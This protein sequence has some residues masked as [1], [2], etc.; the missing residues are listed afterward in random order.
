MGRTSQMMLAEVQAGHV[1]AARHLG[2]QR[3]GSGP[4]G[5][6]PV[7]A[8]GT[9]RGARTSYL[10]GW[11]VIRR[12]GFTALKPLGNFSLASSSDTAGVIT[13]SS[14]SFQ[15]TGVATL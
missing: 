4:N 14:P 5:P 15:F 13:T 10:L 9:P 12:Y 11:G 2:P 8:V 3:H 1:L 7:C 6:D